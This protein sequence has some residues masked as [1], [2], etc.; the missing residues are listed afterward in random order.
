MTE[1]P[2]DNSKKTQRNQLILFIVTLI[3]T[4]MAGAEWMTNKMLFYGEDRMTWSDFLGGLAYS[5]PL[6]LILSVHEFGHYFM[7][8]YHKIKVTLP[9][10]IPLW[11]GF[12]GIPSFGTMGAVIRIKEAIL[13]RKGYFDVG[14]AGPLAGFVIAFFVLI[15]GFTHLPDPEIIY[16][17]HPEYEQFGADYADEVYSYEFR[18][19]QHHQYYKSYRQQ[20][21]TQYL[22]KNNSMEGWHYDEFEPF[23]SYESHSMGTTLLF[24]WM[25]NWLV[26]DPR[27]IPNEFE[28]MHY[29][30]LFA[31]FLAL[32][33]TALN[34]IPIGQLDGGHIL[35]G[36]A[37]PKWHKRLAQV[38]FIAFVYFAG[39]GMFHP[40]TIGQ[41]LINELIYLGFLYFCFYR[42][43]PDY[44]DR[45]MFALGI[46][47]AQIVTVMILPDVKGY[48]G[49]LLFSLVLG[50]FIGIYHPPVLIDKPLDSR[51]KVLGWVAL[52]VFIISF[53]PQP[54]NV[55]EIKKPQ[56]NEEM[57]E[58]PTFLSAMNPSPNWT[59]I[60]IPNSR[61]LPSMKCINSREEIKVFD[62]I[63]SGSKNCDL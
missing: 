62:R 60:D 37:G 48:M 7:A 35:Y 51:R 5:V 44:K 31:G 39:L 12:I 43:S 32:F 63:P 19:F 53:S 58:T 42:F 61:A 25:K 50:R 20:D 46:F 9:Y 23:P 36:M 40:S 8:K 21:S 52:F 41:D 47:A 13:E 14:I 16:D 54:F 28:I 57:S 27:L 1:D 17:I 30:I 49:W 22:E 38:L 3:T 24:E 45:V 11:F 29:P 56:T 15:Y 26:D 33:F 59:R 6:L 34:L 2:I 55:H 4:T 10:Y 18:V